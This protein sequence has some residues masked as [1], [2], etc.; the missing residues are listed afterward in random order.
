[1]GEGLLKNKFNRLFEM[2]ENKSC[3]VAEKVRWEEGAWRWE[4]NWGSRLRGRA[5][6]Q[7]NYLLIT[8][9]DFTHKENITDSW[10]WKAAADG[11]FI[12]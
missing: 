5:I 12:V 11:V 3:I 4:W 9:Q 6:R 2:E 1:M 8:L 7:F 10:T